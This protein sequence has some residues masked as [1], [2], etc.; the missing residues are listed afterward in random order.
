[1]HLSVRAVARVCVLV[2]LMCGAGLVGSAN[3]ASAQSN[4]GSGRSVR[5]G[6]LTDMSGVYSDFS[7]DGSV[8]AAELAISDYEKLDPTLKVDLVFADHQNKT[9]V[10]TVTARRWFEDGVDAVVDLVHS[11]SALAVTGTARDLDKVAIISGSSS[12]DLFGKNCSPNTVHW[13]YDSWAVAESLA[14]ATIKSGGRFWFFL[15]S[16]TSAGHTLV[17]DIGRAVNSAGGQV[18]GAVFPPINSADFA[19]YLMSARGW[20]PDVFALVLGGGDFAGAL[21]QAHEFGL[22][23]PG[24]KI[25]AP[26]IFETDVHSLGTDLSQGLRS[27][28]S[29]YWNL[30]EGTRQFASRFARKHRGRMPTM[31]QAGVYAGVLHYLKAVSLLGSASGKAVVA[32]MKAVPTDDPLFG[33]GVIR[34]DGRKMQPMF[35]F[36]VKNSSRAS[37][38]WDYFDIIDTIPAERAIRAEGEGGCDIASMQK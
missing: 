23:R 29:F 20:N 8:V 9:D 5:V 3:S 18:L 33:R 1:M 15:A 36:E 32:Q 7:G 10:A 26:V 14:T 22:V 27:V 11:A 4:M 38:P 37:G 19:S 13:T 21:K 6:V 24:V 35:V 25:V 30:N 16:D 2:G 17:R 31:V 12:S 34:A 28:T